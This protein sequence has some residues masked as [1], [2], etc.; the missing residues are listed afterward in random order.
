MLVWEKD[1]K[2]I[3]TVVSHSIERSD[4]FKTTVN[5]VPKTDWS[6]IA[7]VVL[8]TYVKVF[9]LYTFFSFVPLITRA[10]SVCKIIIKAYVYYR[11]SW[12]FMVIANWNLKKKYI[13][14][15]I[16][17]YKKTTLIWHIYLVIRSKKNSVNLVHVHSVTG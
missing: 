8:Y 12:F 6:Q 15:Y 10:S 13:Y 14:I 11:N 2:E 5:Y 3:L 1:C 16:V 4:Y 9:T 17:S 7:F